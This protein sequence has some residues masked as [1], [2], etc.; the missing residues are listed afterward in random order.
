MLKVIIIEDDIAKLGRVRKCLEGAAAAERE[1]MEIDDAPDA[2]TAK[3]LLR[4]NRYDFMILD[5]TLPERRDEEAT[6]F[7]GIALF[8]EV[9][10]RDIYTTPQHI[11]GLT[12]FDE[13]V[14]GA[15]RRFADDLWLVIKYDPTTDEWERQLGRKMRHILVAARG[16]ESS[17]E[18]GTDLCVITALADPE[19]QSV[20]RL[21][22]RWERIEVP[23]DPSVYHKGQFIRGDR[24]GNVVAACA[25]RM[26]MTA[27]AILS[28]KMIAAFC[29]RYLAMVGILAGVKGQCQLGDI[30]A[31]DPGW[32]WG[33]GKQYLKDGSP[34]FSA[35]PHQVGVN[36]AIRSRLSLMAQQGHVIDE[37]R[38]GW[39]GEEPASP[40]RMHLGPIASG[41]AVLEDPH[42]TELIVSQH[43]KVIGIDMETY[44]VLAAAEECSL[45]QPKAFCLK[46]VSDFAD[47]AKNDSMRKYASYTSATAFRIFV[48]RYL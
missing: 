34:I 46:S 1:P 13:V 41:A 3:Q 6:P 20:L 31:A 18:F 30:L 10:R 19:L 45:P 48:E 47:S 21:P 39:D 28:M 15:A 33:S 43:R 14:E 24:Q 25:P 44:A 12:A 7:G 38:R 36:A 9:L 23:N 8:E 35:A 5:I 4:V 17:R 40:L 29:P 2:R 27:A 42:F 32:D 22:W 16:K 37:I 11:V 26:G